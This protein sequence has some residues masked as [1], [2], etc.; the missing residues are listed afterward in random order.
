MIRKR[1]PAHRVRRLVA[2]T[3]LAIAWSTALVARGLATPEPTATAQLPPPPPTAPAA[4][5][6]PSSMPAMPAG[7]LVVLHYTPVDKPAPEVRRVVV[8]RTVTAPAPAP[9][10]SSS[11]S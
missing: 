8:T 4:P 11:G 7:G 2:W 9:V 3:S 5:T 1:F 10:A 6:V